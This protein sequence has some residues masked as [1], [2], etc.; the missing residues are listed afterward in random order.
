MENLK[1]NCSELKRIFLLPGEYY[2]TKTPCVIATLLG[3]CVS[4]CVYNE[5][6]LTAAM[7]HFIRDKSNSRNEKQIGKFGDLSIR[8]IIDTLFT[9]DSNAR[10][11]KAK[12]FGGGNV[13]GH[14]EHIGLAIGEQNIFAAKEA[15]LAYKIPIVENKTAGK[16]GMK[17]YFNT[18]NYTVDSQYIGEEKKNFQTRKIRVL[19]V[20]DSELVR[21]LLTKVV[22]QTDDM[23]V[24]GQAKDAYEAR[25]LMLGTNPDVISLDIVMPKIDGLKFLEKI[26]GCVPKPVVIVSTIA[27]NMS[28]IAMKAKQLGAV[29]VIDKEEL[30][31]YNGLGI[32]K[33]KYIPALRTAAGQI[34][35]KR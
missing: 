21:N 5:H 25:D 6:N 9:L 14:L 17:I 7:N 31:L 20:D 29:G 13:V 19:I 1:I 3:S 24:V 16:Q 8:Y 12:I 27:K 2:I 32:V 10:H 26:M 11:Y 30:Q 35:R 4:V 23:E 28:K 15:L 34:V 33:M 18:L 22:S